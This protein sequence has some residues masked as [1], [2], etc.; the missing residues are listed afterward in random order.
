MYTI[1]SFKQNK[2]VIKM[3]TSTNKKV[4]KSNKNKTV[5]VGTELAVVTTNVV[6]PDVS[7]SYPIIHQ[8]PVVS[9]EETVNDFIDSTCETIV[10]Q[11]VVEEQEVNEFKSK[12]LKLGESLGW[13]ELY[14][15][16]TVE[17]TVHIK[18]KSGSKSEK[19]VDIY[20]KMRNEGFRRI[21]IIKQ[22]MSEL[23]MSKD[24]ASTY[25]QNIKK[26]MGH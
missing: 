11:E 17:T 2:K 22:F 16:L 26:K 9:N 18:T 24:G 1:I 4:R 25:Y 15:K 13:E 12:V 19:S 8:L 7:F 6:L 23:D 3:T 21:D 14:L 10:E 5:V 20:V